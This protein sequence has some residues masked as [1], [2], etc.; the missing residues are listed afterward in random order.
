MRQKPN[1]AF[2]LVELLVVIAIIGVLVALLLPAVQAA[3]EAARRSWCANNLTQ[4]ILAVQNYESSYRVYPPGT[5]D[6]SGPIANVTEGYHHNWL[7]QILPFIEERNTFQ[8][9]DFTVGVYHENNAPVRKV[10]VPS[11]SCPSDG[12][13]PADLGLSNYVGSQHDL[14]EPIDVNN[15]GVFFLN[16]RVRYEDVS[17]GTCQTLFI[18]EKLNDANK[19]FGWMSGTR[20]TLR[21]TGTRLNVDVPARY[22]QP[23]PGVTQPP[24]PEDPKHLRVGGFSSAH[25]GGLEAAFGDG[26]VAFLANTLDQEVLQQLA[27][28]ADGKLLL[29]RDF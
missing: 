11:F 25:P 16:S 12:A 1:P 28:R 8:H 22:A 19:D 4:L 27:H 2:T 26:H 29:R 15:H 21:N 17:D 14:E 13:G 6:K 23:R 5:I 3:R 9:I 10:H 20:A 7:S 24:E 18:A